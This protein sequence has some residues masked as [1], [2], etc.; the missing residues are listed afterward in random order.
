MAGTIEE[1]QDDQPT[2]EAPLDN[3]GDITT[4]SGDI[5]DIQTNVDA[6]GGS[7]TSVSGS[8]GITELNE[9]A[10]VDVVTEGRQD[11]S[12]LVYSTATNKWTS[13][14]KLEK[15]LINGGFF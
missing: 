7:I 8:G 6:S 14:L 9:L 11:G 10:D 12:V 2:I 4:T 1:I 5:S 15:Q 3:G 13:T